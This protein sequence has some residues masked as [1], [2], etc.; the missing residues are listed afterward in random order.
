MPSTLGH[1]LTRPRCVSAFLLL[2]GVPQMPSV[3]PRVFS[4][5]FLK[6]TVSLFSSLHPPEGRDGDIRVMT[7]PVLLLTCPLGH[8]ALGSPHLR[9]CTKPGVCR[10]V[11]AFLNKEPASEAAARQGLTRMSLKH[12]RVHTHE[13]A[14]S[15]VCGLSP[16]LA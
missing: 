10:T 2:C 1:Q 16:G 4:R 13:P 6:T 12:P 11:S 5:L 15:P 8:R 3:S 9:S 7:G 14:S